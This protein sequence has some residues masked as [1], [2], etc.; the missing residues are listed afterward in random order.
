MRLPQIQIQT[1]D[2]QMNWKIHDPV[3]R[4]RQPRAEQT[5]SQPPAT[6]R[7]HTTPSNLQIDS[8]DARRDLGYFPTGEMIKRYAQEGRQEMLKGLS[9]RVREGRQMMLSAGKGQGGAVI[10]QI[11]KQNTGP[12]RPGPYNIKFVP[13]IGSVKIK[14]TPATVDVNI[15]RNEPKI[16]VKVNK[17]IHDYT[18][19]KV[20]GTMTQRPRV[21]IDVIG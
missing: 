9:R 8:S 10:Q 17:P 7:I 4:I 19:G 1:T 2:I 5:I 11:A 6:V 15:T 14:Y 3:Q 16:D 21:D 12:K 18:P 13:S 20:T